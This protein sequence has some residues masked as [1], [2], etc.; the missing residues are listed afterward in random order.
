LLA[1][2]GDGRLLATRCENF[3]TAVWVWD[4][5]TLQLAALLIH[6]A[7]VRDVA[8]DAGTQRLALCTGNDKLYLWS[9]QSA[10]I[11]TVPTPGFKAG[12]LAWNA[13]GSAIA[14]TSLEG[15]GAA[16][17]RAYCIAYVGRQL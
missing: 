8:W 2:S 5:A 17:G 10:S 15:E 13:L 3:P 1:W 11:V 16:G 6:L 4:V 7:P 9:P 12:A 14:L